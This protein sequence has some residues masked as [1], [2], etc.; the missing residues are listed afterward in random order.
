MTHFFILEILIYVMKISAILFDIGGVL[1]ELNG[2]PSLAKL[3][4]S[5]QSHDEIYKNWMASPSVIGHETGKLSTDE[6]AVEIVKDLNLDL[7]PEAFM[8]NFMTW[9]V[10]TF[11][12]TFDLLEAIPT[13][14]SIAAL[15]NTSHA[16]WQRVEATGLT[17]KLD[18]L[19]LSHQIG[20]LKPD[21]K[22][23]QA[24]VDGLRL[25]AEEII[26]F[27]DNMQNVH[28]ANEFGLKAHQA[29]NPD[30]ARQVLSQYGII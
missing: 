17:D 3:M 8:D 18:Q 19:F 1:I 2:L 5:Q 9:I 10:G 25:P 30:H 23:F 22:S 12:S 15:S 28:A 27:D 13:T 6:F 11:P 21:H 20:H 29:L 16:H 26:F 24:A 14:M 4:D 7:S